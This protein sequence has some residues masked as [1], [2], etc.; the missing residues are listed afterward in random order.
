MSNKLCKC[1]E[2][3]YCR[4]YTEFQMDFEFGRGVPHGNTRRDRVKNFFHLQHT[5][6]MCR[7]FGTAGTSYEQR[8]K[9]NGPMPQGDELIDSLLN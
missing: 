8:K 6:E 2:C 3:E 4:A 1:G 5:E 7:E 9:M